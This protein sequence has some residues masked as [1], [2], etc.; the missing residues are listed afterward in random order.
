MHILHRKTKQEIVCFL[1]FLTFNHEKGPEKNRGRRKARLFRTLDIV[2][3][4][5]EV[6]E[7]GYDPGAGIILNSQ[8]I[9][10]QF[11]KGYFFNTRVNTVECH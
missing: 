3:L 1:F 7:P 10:I 2:K 11:N 8:R 6:V 4:N 9:A 5:F